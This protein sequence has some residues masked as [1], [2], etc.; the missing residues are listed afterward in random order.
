MWHSGHFKV[1]NLLE[2]DSFSGI[3]TRTLN[4]LTTYIELRLVLFIGILW[5][6]I[7]R[8]FK[9]TAVVT[10]V[11]SLTSTWKEI[12]QD[13]VENNFV[14]SRMWVHK[15]DCC[16]PKSHFGLLKSVCKFFRLIFWLESI[17]WFMLIPFYQ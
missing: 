9:N 17:Q 10:K 15:R 5:C 16:F 12:L 13:G 8:L 11:S 2:G 14:R 4:K 6:A 1:I 3:L 7:L